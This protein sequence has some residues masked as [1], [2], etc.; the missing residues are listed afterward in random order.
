MSDAK[1]PAASVP[2]EDEL[3]LLEAIYQGFAL[4]AQGE[5]AADLRRIIDRLTSTSGAPAPAPIPENVKKA[6]AFQ[7]ARMSALAVDPDEP[8]SAPT[9]PTTG[10]PCSKC[11]RPVNHT[12]WGT[13]VECQRIAKGDTP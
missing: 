5:T 10:Y 12:L 7:R 9:M 11:N 8:A 2:T 6:A 3:E 1:T 13:C 4:N